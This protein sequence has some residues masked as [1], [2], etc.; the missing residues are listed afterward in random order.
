MPARLRLHHFE[1]RS[2]AN[3]PGLHFVLWLQ[4]CPLGCPGCFN[5]QTHPAAGGAW[6]SIAELTALIRSVEGI[7]GITLSGGEPLEQAEA[8]AGLLSHLRAETNLSIL[9]FSGYTWDE[10]ERDP[11]KHRCAALADVVLAGRYDPNRRLAAGLR[12]SANKTVHFITQRYTQK[13]LD[14]VPDAEVWINATGEVISSGI[15]PLQWEPNGKS[16]F[17]G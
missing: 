2:A 7:E 12:G 16:T 3:G 1:P 6:K 14:A 17:A 15:D 10:I 13:D 9:L 8:L 5:P 11:L 4:G